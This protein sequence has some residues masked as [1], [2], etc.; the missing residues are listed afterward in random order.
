MK[1]FNVEVLYIDN[2][3]KKFKDLYSILWHDCSLLR[4]MIFLKGEQKNTTYHKQNLYLKFYTNYTVKK[5]I[6]RVR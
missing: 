4:V 3:Q 5:C 2:H 1:L 6:Q